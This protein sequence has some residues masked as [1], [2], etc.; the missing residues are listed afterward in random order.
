MFGNPG[1]MPQETSNFASELVN[2]RKKMCSL[3]DLILILFLSLQQVKLVHN[4]F[5]FIKINGQSVKHTHMVRSPSLTA[6]DDLKKKQEEEFKRHKKGE[7]P[8]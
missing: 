1:N 8:T 4:N 2:L 3:L 5:D 6:L 7:V